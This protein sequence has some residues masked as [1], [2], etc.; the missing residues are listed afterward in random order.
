MRWIAIFEDKADALALRER[1]TAEHMAYLDAHRER[2]LLP[3]G[4]RPVPGGALQGGLWVMEVESR[5]EAVRLCE[6]DPFFRHGLRHTYR[7][8]VW[9]KAF[10]DRRV[11]L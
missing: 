6:D 4:M 8:A 1:F 11:T 3:G 9:G 5:E 2:I 7:L 10:P